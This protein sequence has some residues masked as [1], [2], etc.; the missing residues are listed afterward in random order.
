MHF[1]VCVC[2]FYYFVAGMS[3]A[4]L[5]AKDT[6]DSMLLSAAREVQVTCH[7]HLLLSVTTCRHYSI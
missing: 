6:P 1:S 7:Q 2:V 5:I 3:L 4:M